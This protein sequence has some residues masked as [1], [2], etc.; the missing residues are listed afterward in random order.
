MISDICASRRVIV[1]ELTTT[2]RTLDVSNAVVEARFRSTP[3]AAERDEEDNSRT[4][5]KILFVSESNACRSLLAQALME[6]LLQ[7]HHLS[8]A[9]KCESKV[10]EVC[11]G[12]FTVVEVCHSKFSLADIPR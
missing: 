1:Q 11:C 7:K 2:G 10:R 6:H 9:V 5:A 8:D 12:A 3:W 4:Y